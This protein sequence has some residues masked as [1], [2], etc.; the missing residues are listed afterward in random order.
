VT[1]YRNGRRLEWLARDALAAEGYTVIR[2]AGSHGPVDLVAWN[3]KRVRLV[4]VK[5]AGSVRPK[6][7]PAL[8]GLVVPM[9][10]S[11]ELW[12]RHRGG[13]RVTNAT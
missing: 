12:E 4:Q 2:A 8:A 9:G 11:V 1:N 5:S 3:A 6:D 13:W 7:R 10:A